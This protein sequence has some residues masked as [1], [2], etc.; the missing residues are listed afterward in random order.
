M[1]PRRHSHVVNVDE[2][3]ATEVARG[4]HQLMRRK[5]GAAAGNQQL[6]ASVYEV[7]PGARS[8]PFHWHGA[9]EE[10]VYVIAGRG[11]ARLGDATVAIR[12]GDWLAFPVG[13]AHVHQLINDGDEPLRYLCVATNHTC[14]IVGYPDSRKV[15]AL[16]GADWDTLWVDHTTRA[17]AD[18]DYWDG[19]PGA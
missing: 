9:N 18:L 6:G 2:V 3:A 11:T 16:A 19:E 13:P 4:Q 10:A 12:A 8:Y 1:G 7:P 17:D 15:K 5:L 14:E